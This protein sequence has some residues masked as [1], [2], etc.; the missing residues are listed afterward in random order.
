MCPQQ[1]TAC[2]PQSQDL[3]PNT[4]TGPISLHL[5]VDASR[6]ELWVTLTNLLHPA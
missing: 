1:T 2:H 3:S 4:Q 5:S 6:V